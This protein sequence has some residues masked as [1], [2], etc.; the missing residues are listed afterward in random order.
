MIQIF[1]LG[2][3]LLTVSFKKQN[4]CVP[5]FSKVQLIN[6]CFMDCAWILH[7][8]YICLI[9]IHKFFLLFILYYIILITMLYHRSFV[10][11]SFP[12]SVPLFNFESISVC[13]VEN[14]SKFIYLHMDINYPRLFVEKTI[15]SILI[16]LK[17]Y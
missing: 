11:L 4:L 8:G 1:S 6:S 10:V 12:C 7:L 13:G 15:F 5:N 14:G 2:L 17:V 3:W 16:G 9:Q